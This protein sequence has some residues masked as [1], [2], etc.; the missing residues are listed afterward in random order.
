M[1]PR[2]YWQLLSRVEAGQQLIRKGSVCLRRC[3]ACA[4]IFIVP[5]KKCIREEALNMAMGRREGAMTNK[6]ANAPRQGSPVR[7][8]PNSEDDTLQYLLQ[9]SG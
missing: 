4:G 5:P 9:T 1:L 2:C 6:A 3:V 8:R 7:K